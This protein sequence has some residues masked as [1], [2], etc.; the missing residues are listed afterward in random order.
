L[1]AASAGSGRR[2][3]LMVLKFARVH[4]VA[5]VLYTLSEGLGEN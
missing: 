5:R 2:R 4:E 3:C 1:V